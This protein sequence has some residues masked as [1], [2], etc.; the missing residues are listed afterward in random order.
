MRCVSVIGMAARME[1]RRCRNDLAECDTGFTIQSRRT[2]MPPSTIIGL[3]VMN[4]DRS[5]RRKSAA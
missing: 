3:P 1:G 5:E 4:W 2:D